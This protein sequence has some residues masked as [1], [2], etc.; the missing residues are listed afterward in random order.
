[1][2]K[3]IIEPGCITCGACEFIEPDV[4]QVTDICHVKKDAKLKEHKE[5]IKQAAQACP[6]QVITYEE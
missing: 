6:V 5:N 2:K 4:F 3:V 1:M